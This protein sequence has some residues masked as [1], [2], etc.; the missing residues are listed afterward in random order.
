[1]SPKSHLEFGDLTVSVS[2]LYVRNIECITHQGTLLSILSDETVSNKTEHPCHFIQ[3]NDKFVR[4]ISYPVNPALRLSFEKGSRKVSALPETNKYAP[5]KDMGKNDFIN[6]N[7]TRGKIQ[8]AK[9]DPQLGKM[10]HS[11]SK[12]SLVTQSLLNLTSYE[13]RTFK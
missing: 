13:V 3:R 5:R 9:S 1:M 10:K 7:F 4:S 2:P 6:N 8:V 11:S 12:D